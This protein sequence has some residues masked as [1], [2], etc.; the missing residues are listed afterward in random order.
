MNRFNS[1]AVGILAICVGLAGILALASLLLFFLGMWQDIRFLQSMGGLNDRI[2]IVA[3]FLSAFLASALFPALRP[4]APRLS[5]LLL[6]GAWAGAVAVTFGSWLIITG[7][8]EVELSSYYFFYGNGLIGMWLF[9]LNRM[10]RQAAAWTR[11][12][13]RLGTVAS[14]FMTVGL[15]GLY[16]ILLGLDGNDYPPLVLVAGISFLGTGILYPVWALWL[17]RRIYSDPGISEG[18]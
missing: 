9:L 17:A 4:R 7:R 16:G 2:N 15:L 12:L 10:A 5:A 18:E 6:I 11:A 14:L 3:S 8:A 13:T 1:R